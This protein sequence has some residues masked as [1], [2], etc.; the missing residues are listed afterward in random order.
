MP[1]WPGDAAVFP[2]CMPVIKQFEGFRAK[3]YKDSAGIPTIG[4]G[5]IRYPDGS[6]VTMRVAVPM[7]EAEG[8]ASPVTSL[9]A[10]PEKVPVTV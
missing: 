9:T 10:V 2:L 8:S 7:I 5:T 3:P 1:N 6:A 4:Y